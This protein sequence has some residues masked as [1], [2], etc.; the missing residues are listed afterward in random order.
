M[1]NLHTARNNVD[2]SNKYLCSV[3]LTTG[4]YAGLL[5]ASR[6]N[7]GT[8]ENSLNQLEFLMK[9][10]EGIRSLS[11]GIESIKLVILS[12]DVNGG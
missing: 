5:D 3:L 10:G 9:S 8:V 11:R 1:T 6:Q 7:C 2:H 4:F 12:D